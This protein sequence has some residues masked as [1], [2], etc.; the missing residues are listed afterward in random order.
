MTATPSERAGPMPGF[1]AAGPA[2]DV[3]RTLLTEAQFTT[4]AVCRRL[5]I[6]SVYDF[7]SIREGRPGD[8]EATDALDVL[9]RLY[10][11]VELVEEAVIDRLMGAAGVRTLEAAGLLSAAHAEPTRRHATVLLYPTAGLWI[12]S[13]LHVSPT[14]ASATIFSDDAVYPA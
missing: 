13:D 9:I 4:E 2:L 10:M 1:P 14:G 3:L 7:Q 11:D 5:G 6:A 8:T 12:A